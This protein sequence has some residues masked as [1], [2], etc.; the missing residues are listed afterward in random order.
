MMD[1]GDRASAG[2]LRLESRSPIIRYEYVG[3]RMVGEL[4]TYNHRGDQAVEAKEGKEERLVEHLDD[5]CPNKTRR[6]ST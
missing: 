3:T 1:G 6:C 4:S 2:L 5:S